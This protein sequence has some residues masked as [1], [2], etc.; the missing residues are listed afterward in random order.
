M[1]NRVS[2]NPA[3][4]AFASVLG[5]GPGRTLVA[6]E[7]GSLRVQMGWAFRCEIPLAEIKSAQLVEDPRWWWGIGAHRIG[8]NRWIVN[9]TMSDLVEIRMTK[10]VRGRA[11]GIAVKVESLLISVADPQALLTELE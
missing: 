4:G 2:F 1:S 5:I 11:L 7:A 10:P 8:P 9:G 6:V 3:W